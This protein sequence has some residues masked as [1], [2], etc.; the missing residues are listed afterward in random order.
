MISSVGMELAVVY[1]EEGSRWSR[2]VYR[3][4]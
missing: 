2:V 1:N 4:Y 3:V